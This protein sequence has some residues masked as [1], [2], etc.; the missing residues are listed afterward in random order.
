MLIK[1]YL[2][3]K[4]YAAANLARAKPAPAM[5]PAAAAALDADV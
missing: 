4:A 5:T 2:F 1:T 3:A